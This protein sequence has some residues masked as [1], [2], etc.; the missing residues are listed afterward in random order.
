[1]QP[2]KLIVILLMLHIFFAAYSN[3]S[4]QFEYLTSINGLS[5]NTVYDI[6]QDVEG[7]MWFATRQGLCR[8]DGYSIKTYYHNDDENSLLD[9]NI[10]E[11]HTSKKGRLLIGTPK[12]LC[13]YNKTYDHF[14]AILSTYD[15]RPV[16]VFKITEL[17]D[18]TILIASNEGLFSLNENMECKRISPFFIRDLCEYKTGIIWALHKNS[19]AVLNKEGELIQRINPK[20]TGLIPPGIP[21]TILWCIHTDSDGNVWVGTSLNGINYYLPDEEKF[22][23]LKLKKNIQSIEDNFVRHIT[24]DAQKRIWIGTESGI[25]IYDKNTQQIEHIQQSFDF[26]DKKLNDKAI[27]S[28]YMSRENIAWIGTYFG[29]VNYSPPFK[30]GFLK[31]HADGGIK[32]LSGNAISQIIEVNQNELWMATEDGGITLYNKK[33]NRFSYFRNTSSKSIG[34]TSNNIHALT[35]DADGNVY[36]GTFIGGL[37]KYVKRTGRIVSIALQ[38]PSDHIDKSVYSIFIDSKNRKWIGTISGLYLSDPKSDHFKFFK[39]NVFNNKF[40]YDI[41]EDKNGN[42]YLCTRFSGLYKITDTDKVVRYHTENSP[43]F[44]SNKIIFAHWDHHNNLWLGTLE[45]GIIKYQVESGEF[46]NYTTM[47]GLPDNNVYS[48][49]EDD[50]NYLWL[51]TNKGISRFDPVKIEFTNYTENDGLIGNQFN[52]KS[53]F[54][55]SDGTIYFGAVNGLTYFNPNNIQLNRYKPLIHFTDF[56]LFNHSVPI[57]KNGVLTKHINYVDKIELK[58]KF[59]VFSIDF[60]ALNYFT[61]GNNQYSYYLDGFEETW[62]NVGNK[63]SATYTNLSPGSYTFKLKAA[64]N[65]GIYSNEKNLIIKVLPPFW[66]SIWGYLL[67]ALVLAAVIALYIRYVNLRQQEKLKIEM[68]RVEK[69]K[70]EELNRHRLNFF[71]FISHEFK[72]PLT[73]ILATLEHFLYFEEASPIFKK[74][75]TSIRK[76]AL[77]LLFLINQLMEF[78]KIESDHAAVKLR[79]GDII[80]YIKNIFES[81]RPLFENKE[82]EGWFNSNVETYVTWFDPDK[83]EKILTNLVSNSYKSFELDGRIS[84]DIA[85]EPVTANNYSNQDSSQLVIKLSDNGKGLSEEMQQKIFEPFFSDSKVTKASSGIGLALVNGLIKVLHGSIHVK[86]EVDKGSTFTITIPMIDNPDNKH[87]LSDDVID[88]NAMLEVDNSFLENDIHDAHE[89]QADKILENSQQEI[90]L[91]EDNQELL[92]FLKY[93]FIKNYKVT[94]AENGTEALEKIEKSHPDIVISDVMMPKMDGVSLCNHIKSTFETSHIPVVLLTAKTSVEAKLEGLD[95]GADMYINKPFNLK[96]LELHIRNILSARN[97][98]KTHLMQFGSFNEKVTNLTNKDQKFIEN[99]TKI[100][101]NNLDNGK[102]DVNMFASEAGVSRTLLHIKLK[103]ITGLS[104]TEFI[105]T[106]RLGEARKML[107]EDGYS[108]SEVAYK[109]GFND[110]TYF[111]RSFKKMFDISPSEARGKE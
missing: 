97:N 102:L 79:N 94:L 52:F 9:N 24:E 20:S 21:N 34:L 14:D 95:K 65:D 81:F 11:I 100:I 109:V 22:K 77:R 60:I 50:N 29:G 75:G 63:T 10:V 93:H 37:N 8:Y 68:A 49:V 90:L 19:I 2:K 36:I 96:E 99:L 76:N 39:P 98:L 67:Y 89:T 62:N 74:Y 27:Y 32:K 59:N 42:I 66:L 84:L 64:N 48:I 73:L 111:S 46:T 55:D 101:H 13:A 33:N 12:G 72:T 58:H 41:V 23:S 7:Y 82:I 61:E 103:K 6:T 28:I 78:R 87:K 17:K 71:T 44:S 38:A 31:M 53:G 3:S 26:Y 105:K 69:E 80:K 45:G 25:Y 85:I 47:H 110:P 88:Y 106:I 30:K 86:S 104:T 51:S 35:E 40:I 4:V 107:I 57:K 5:H 1:M 83:Y 43:A 108:V 56:K 92:N 16:H 70:V 15:N 54:K 91:V 18:G